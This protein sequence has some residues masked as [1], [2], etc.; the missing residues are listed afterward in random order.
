MA[1]Q[2][3]KPKL[4]LQSGAN[5]TQ[6]KKDVKKIT[7][8]IN[9]QKKKRQEIND[10]IASYRAKLETMGIHK[11]AADMAMAYMSW[12]PEKREGFD[13]AY[14][15]VREAMGLPVSDDLFAAADEREAEERKR[16]QQAEADSVF[17]ARREEQ[18]QDVTDR[19]LAEG[20]TVLEGGG[21][22]PDDFDKP[23]HVDPD[24]GEDTKPV[25]GKPGTLP[26]IV[27]DQRGKER[28]DF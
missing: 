10:Q 2:P 28:D 11:K 21:E 7:D 16:E 27:D 22:K 4:S 17:A 6:L 24:T 20:E 25:N 19:E 1:M 8:G 3:E 14:A 13:I 23:V 5:L 15:I 26:P 12:E 18:V 9:A